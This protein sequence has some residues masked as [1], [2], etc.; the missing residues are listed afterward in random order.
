MALGNFKAKFGLQVAHVSNLSPP[1]AALTGYDIVPVGS[2][3]Y[4]AG[5]TLSIPTGWLLCDGSTVSR[6][7][8]PDL[9]VLLS[10]AGYPYGNGD[11]ST[12]F[13][14]PDTRGR[15][16]RYGTFPTVTQGAETYTLID[17]DISSHAHPLAGHAHTMGS[18]T[19][20]ALT[21]TH[22]ATTHN[23]GGSNPH[24]H[25][26]TATGD[27]THNYFITTP[28]PAGTGQVRNS[29][30]PPGGSKFLT[31]NSVGSHLHS[32][33]SDAGNG[34]GAAEYTDPSNFG[35]PFTQT[36]PPATSAANSD[37]TG[38]S[39]PATTGNNGN[40][41]AV[42]SSFSLMQPFLV[43]NVIIRAA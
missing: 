5:A 19:H 10:A 18:H 3:M 32:S 35:F 36:D 25:G 11:G 17:S 16:L 29:S 42:R 6:T 20:T 38:A 34:S 4:W 26:I 15:A 27:H 1:A 13:T 22:T 21:H 12:T 2:M 41:P 33:T 7:T 31:H 24:N 23:H 8:Y 40:V 14:L 9:N 39:S 37:L 30:T 43:M 28:C